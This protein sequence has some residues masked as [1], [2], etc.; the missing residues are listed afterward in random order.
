MRTSSLLLQLALA[1]TAAAQ[2]APP[3]WGVVQHAGN[4]AVEIQGLPGSWLAVP[5]SVGP[6]DAVASSPSQICWTRGGALNIRDRQTGATRTIPAPAGPARFAFDSQGALA[7]VW[8]T[9]AGQLYT[10]AAGW[11][12]VLSIPTASSQLLDLLNPDPDAVQLLL[13]PAGAGRRAAAKTASD[14]PGSRIAVPLR[15]A[16]VPDLQLLVI[17]ALTGQT[18]TETALA[19]RSGPAAL[20]STGDVVFAADAGLPAVDSIQHLDRGWLLLTAAS[21]QYAWKPGMRPQGFGPIPVSPDLKVLSPL[22][23]MDVGGTITMPS[24]PAGTPVQEDFEI[25]NTAATSYVCLLNLDFENHDGI[26]SMPGKIITPWILMPAS[27]PDFAVSLPIQFL[28]QAQ[29]TYQNTLNIEYYVYNGTTNPSICVSA[30]QDLPS[31]YTV[32]LIKPP[33]AGSQIIVNGTG[34]APLPGPELTGLSPDSN[35]VG[36]PS[37]TLTLT[38]GGFESDSQVQWVTENP[39]TFANTTTSLPTVYISATQLTASVPGSLLTAVGAVTLT[40]NNPT[41]NAGVSQGMVFSI[42]GTAAP[43]V[44]STVQLTLVLD[45]PAPSSNSQVKVS[46][47]L[48]QNAPTGGFAGGLLTLTFTPAA[49]LADDPSIFLDGNLQDTRA[50][51]FTVPAG[52]NVAAFGTQNFV[53]LDTGTTAGTFTLIAALGDKSAQWGPYVIAATAAPVITSSTLGIAASGIQLVLQGF[54]ASQS[55]SGLAFEF[56]ATDG[57]VVSPGLITMDSSSLISDFSTYYKANTLLGGKFQLTANFPVT[58]DV[59]QIAKASVTLS[60]PTGAASVSVPVQ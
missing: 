46:V 52:A 45:Q 54:D 59:T 20:D 12:P 22:T 30:E 26:F 27:G 51:Q 28:P 40:V 57:T 10:A 13:R 14:L 32:T 39:V 1:T 29:A 35:Q 53:I 23:N 34:T 56:Y 2:I 60:N 58:G 11:A 18:R 17:D 6:V 36:A 8:F 55:T 41:S 44:P 21:H 19:D 5:A 42:A 15:T 9:A 37:F 31:G 48:N 50:Q 47:T 16:A 38:G 25:D 24:T 3:S 4:Q 33:A 43:V 7:A 49:N